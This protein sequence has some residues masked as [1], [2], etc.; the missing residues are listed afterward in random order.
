MHLYPC[1]LIIVKK[2][3]LFLHQAFVV[4]V[5]LLV[6]WN[7]L[8]TTLKVMRDRFKFVCSS[9]LRYFP[10]FPESVIFLFFCLYSL[11]YLTLWDDQLTKISNVMVESY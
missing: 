1:F 6:Y 9:N 7:S 3:P 8:L 10:K 11:N 2:V 4:L 5:F